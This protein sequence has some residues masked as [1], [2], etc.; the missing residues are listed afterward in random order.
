MAVRSSSEGGFRTTTVLAGMSCRRRRSRRNGAMNGLIMAG[1]TRL[2]R[3]DA[4]A[5]F[6]AWDRVRDRWW[7]LNQIALS[8]DCPPMRRRGGLVPRMQGNS[9]R[10]ARAKLEAG[11][12]SRFAE[13]MNTGKAGR[14]PLCTERPSHADP[15]QCHCIPAHS[16]RNTV[17]QPNPAVSPTAAGRRGPDPEPTHR[18]RRPAGHGSERRPALRPLPR[19]AQSGG[20]VIPPGGAHPAAAAPVP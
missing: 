1:R 2:P 8:Q 9:R 3:R 6:Q 19:G 11:L 10:T 20:V 5:R 7:A 16:L 17:S 4:R 12:R 15:A 18:C 13:S 14:L